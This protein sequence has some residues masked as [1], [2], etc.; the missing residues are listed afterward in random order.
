MSS[1]FLQILATC[2]KTA[3]SGQPL[4]LPLKVEKKV[5]RI[6]LYYMSRKCIMALKGGP[7]IL[8]LF[9]KRI[10]L[11]TNLSFTN[12]VISLKISTRT[13]LKQNIELHFKE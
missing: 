6:E 13:L 12:A 11:D 2:L 7:N 1:Q 8:L 9:A 10:F 3:L 5:R 4:T